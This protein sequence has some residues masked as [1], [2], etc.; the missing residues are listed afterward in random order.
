MQI[1]KN[2]EAYTRNN[3][4]KHITEDIIKPNKW[5]IEIEIEILNEKSWR[6]P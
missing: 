2:I 6:S 3:T 5:H 1:S 4:H